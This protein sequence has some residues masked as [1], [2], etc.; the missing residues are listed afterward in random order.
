M[1][2][3]WRTF[4]F[5]GSS[6]L[7]YPHFCHPSKKNLMAL[8]TEIKHIWSVMVGGLQHPLHSRHKRPAMVACLPHRKGTSQDAEYRARSLVEVEHIIYA[9]I[10]YPMRSERRTD[11]WWG[12]RRKD[13]IEKVAIGSKPSDNP[14]VRLTS[15]TSGRVNGADLSSCKVRRNFLW[16]RGANFKKIIW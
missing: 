12:R 9:Y 1:L 7:Y 6:L 13:F 14:E 10:L 5:P 11:I 4:V 2:V 3:W 15:S 8:G 16:E